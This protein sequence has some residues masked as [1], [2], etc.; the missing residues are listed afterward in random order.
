[1]KYVGCFLDSHN[2]HVW[3]FVAG[4]GIDMVVGLVWIGW[5]WR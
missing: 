4:V 2:W 1:L 5:F 3:N